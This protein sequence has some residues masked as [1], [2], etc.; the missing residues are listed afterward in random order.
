MPLII[1][2]M[3][4][5]G[6]GFWIAPT[7]MHA[8]ETITG[9]FVVATYNIYCGNLNLPRLS[10]AMAESHADLIALQETNPESERYLRGAL[11][12]HYPYMQFR[13]GQGSEGLGFMSRSPLKDLTYLAPTRGLYGAW[14]VEVQLASNK[15]TVANTH[16]RSPDLSRATNGY[17]FFRVFL[18]TD[19]IQE[20]EI[21]RV[22]ELLP[23]QK[24]VIVLGDF[25]SLATSSPARTLREQGFVDSYA[26]VN[27]HP[28]QTGTWRCR[29][30][31]Y[32][33]AFRI[34]FIFHSPAFATLASRILQTDASDHA[35]LVSRCK[36]SRKESSL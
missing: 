28:D 27:D 1:V 36:W 33:W 7:G 14:L 2:L 26:A 15:V 30:L 6:L 9:E 17:S 23:R 3:L 12:K 24:P 32:A 35:L 10:K 5:G 22:L 18:E 25:N 19:A 11:A 20:G 29:Q 8:A 16:L 31:N 13:A 34:D 4:A 21:H